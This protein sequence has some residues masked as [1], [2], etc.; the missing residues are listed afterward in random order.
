MA[1]LPYASP[2]VE[3]KDGKRELIERVLVDLE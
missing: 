1:E 3:L 2:L